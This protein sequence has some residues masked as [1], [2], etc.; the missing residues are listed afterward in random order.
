MNL[1]FRLEVPWSVAHT[2]TRF[3]S[4]GGAG[5]LSLA[6]ALSLSLMLCLERWAGDLSQL[7]SRHPCLS[8]TL[9]LA[10]EVAGV[11]KVDFGWGTYPWLGRTRPQQSGGKQPL[12]VFNF[13][14][15]AVHT[16]AGPPQFI[17]CVLSSNNGLV[18][19]WF[20]SNHVADHPCDC[21]LR[22]K[23]QIPGSIGHV[24]PRINDEAVLA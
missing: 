16:V 23:Y 17:V 20:C 10:S 13:F 14:D 12:T 4:S 15:A 18:H 2:A 22:G 11:F 3:S 21:T 6:R 19:P 9:C 24:D 7:I 5:F 1:P 8:V